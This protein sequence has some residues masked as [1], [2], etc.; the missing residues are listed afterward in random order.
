MRKT[1]RGG[2]IRFEG[3]RPKEG[4]FTPIPQ[5]GPTT[6]LNVFV[7]IKKIGQIVQ[8]IC[9]NQTNVFVQIMKCF[10]EIRKLIFSQI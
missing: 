2:L 7:K 6:L 9:P 5:P 1:D 4:L 8:H 10:L 3:A